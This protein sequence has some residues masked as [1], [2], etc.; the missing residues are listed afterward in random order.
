MLQ[1]SASHPE[2]ET[3]GPF[4]TNVNTAGMS[5]ATVNWLIW[6]YKSGMFCAQKMINE[7]DYK[8]ANNFWLVIVDIKLC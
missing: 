6:R 4:G 3:W 1:T 7:W 8:M 2:T 5:D